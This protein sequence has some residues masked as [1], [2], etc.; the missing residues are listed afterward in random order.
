MAQSE[1]VASSR[2]AKVKT[3]LHDP[4]LENKIILIR[5]DSLGKIRRFVFLTVALLFT[6]SIPCFAQAWVAPAHTGVVSVLFQRINNTGHRL[7]DGNLDSMFPGKSVDEGI[8]VAVDYALT[9]RLSAE[10]GLP[11]V[12]A[13]YI[14]PNETPNVF[15]PVDNCFCWHGGLQDFDFIVRYN[16]IGEFGGSFALTPSISIGTPSHSY[17]YQGEAV[18]GQNL[19]NITLALDAGLRLDAISPRLALQGRYSYAFVERVQD[20]KIDRSNI[21]VE[22]EW[23][24]TQKLALNG[25]ALWQITHGGLRVPEDLI[26]NPQLGPEH[27][28]LLRDNYFRAGVGASYQL[29]HMDIFATY[30]AF[31]S[32][33]N[34]HAG[35][36][37]TFGTSWPFEL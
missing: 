30:I 13:K 3:K 31:V 9:D 34:T 2:N 5:T 20:I 15:L 37:V 4:A 26:T 11:Y 18:I 25:L 32:G 27:D 28:R 21:V 33:R 16:V 6:T 14:G 8:F 19:N 23:E 29:L 7:N 12:F 35:H 1:S 22:P 10:I 36:V 24:V 17:A